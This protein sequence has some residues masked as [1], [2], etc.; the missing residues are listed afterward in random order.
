MIPDLQ[1]CIL[2]DDVRQ[3]RN[4]KFILIGLFDTINS[5]Q[6]PLVFQRICILSRWCGGEGEYRQLTRLL[7]PDQKTVVIQGREIPVKLPNVEAIVTNVEMFINTVFSEAGVYWIETLLD[8]DLII[9]YPLRVAPIP[10]P[11][12]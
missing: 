9:R 12:G 3:E 2:C 7:K 5:N 6:Y 4:G 1:A 8:N 11:H 10:P